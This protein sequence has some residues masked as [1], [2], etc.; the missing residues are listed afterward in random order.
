MSHHYTTDI[1]IALKL[2]LEGPDR[3]KKETARSIL[4]DPT[5]YINFLYPHEFDVDSVSIDVNSNCTSVT[6][7]IK[8]LKLSDKHI[9][10]AQSEITDEFNDTLRSSISD[11]WGENG[12][13]FGK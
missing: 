7:K 1:T 9:N 10:G 6:L 4:Q 8:N 2:K 11:G 5:T 12:I 13:P 3:N